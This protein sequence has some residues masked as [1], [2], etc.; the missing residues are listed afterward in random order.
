VQPER[1]ARLLTVLK[2][3]IREHTRKVRCDV[4]LARYTSFR[5]GGPAD[6]FVEPDTLDELQAV[7][8]VVRA[9]QLPLFILGGGTNLL[10]SDNGVRGVV[11]KLGGG[12]NYTAWE[13]PEEPEEPEGSK[14]FA[15]VRQVR[16]GAGHSLGRF[17]RE[18]VRKGYAGVEFAEGIPGSVGGGLLM[19]AGAFGGELSQVVEAIQGVDQT[20]DIASLAGPSLGFAYRRTAL[21]AGFIVTEILLRL[22]RQQ[23]DHLRAAMQQAQAKRHAGQP[24]GYPNAGSIFKNPAGTYAGRLIEAAGLKGTVCGQA[25]V[26]QQHANFIVNTGGARAAEVK[27]LMEQ[28]QRTVWATHQVWLEPEIRLVGDWPDSEESCLPSNLPSILRASRS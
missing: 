12:F 7:V 13:E 11:V 18:A 20:A 24:H 15:Q 3:H 10:I 14:A 21:P 22:R 5:I 6:V 1:K 27:Q 8:S 25:Q 9:E 16:V 28:V 19:N 23:A 4:P 26:S 2:E 17:V